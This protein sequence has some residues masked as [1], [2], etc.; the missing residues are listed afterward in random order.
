[1]NINIIRGAYEAPKAE[2]V[3]MNAVWSVLTGS[4]VTP[5][6][7]VTGSGFQFGTDNGSW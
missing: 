7:G 5:D 1:M 2:I 4:P 3:Q 6:A